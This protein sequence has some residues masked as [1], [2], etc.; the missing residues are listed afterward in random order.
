MSSYCHDI[1]HIQSRY[2]MAAITN[3]TGRE[4]TELHKLS[5]TLMID[6]G[7]VTEEYFGRPEIKTT[8]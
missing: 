4:Y 1:S 2:V 5:W 8:N 3:P 7:N 6:R